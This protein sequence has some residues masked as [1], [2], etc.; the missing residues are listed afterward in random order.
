MQ[1]IEQMSRLWIHEVWRV[2]GDRLVNDDDRQFLFENIRKF[3][4]KNLS[5][6]IDNLF[7]HLYTSK[8][9]SQQIFTLQLMRN[10]LWSDIL[11]PT[12]S[13]KRY[14]EEIVD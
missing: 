13:P 8:D 12:G 2:F 14:Y 6:N 10:L 7:Q 9:K 11:T 5:V 3:V 1:N 4:T